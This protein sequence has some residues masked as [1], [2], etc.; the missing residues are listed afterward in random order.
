VPQGST[1]VIIMQVFGA[2]TEATT[3]QLRIIDGDLKYYNKNV[4]AAN[5]Y[6]KWVRLNVIHNVGAAKVTIFIDG[7]QKLEMNGHGRDTHYFK[8]GAY[9][10]LTGS[11]NYMESRWKGIKVFKK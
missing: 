2:A 8:Y 4:V 9:A 11:S 3:L 1:G 7:I 6:N 10:A 5:V